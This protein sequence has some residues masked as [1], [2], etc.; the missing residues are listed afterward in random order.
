MLLVLTNI[1][2][3]QTTLM[4]NVLRVRRLH[5]V[6]GVGVICCSGGGDMLFVRVAGMVGLLPHKSF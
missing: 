4:E 5:V 3:I 1:Y 6:V 2:K